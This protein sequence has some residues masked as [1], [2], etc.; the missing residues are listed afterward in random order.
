MFQVTYLCTHGPDYYLSL[1]VT[2]YLVK[3]NNSI[4]FSKEQLHAVNKSFV[5]CWSQFNPIICRPH[6][7]F[8]MKL[9]VLIRYV[10]EK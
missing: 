5:D 9:E 1:H 10:V 8:G 2:L 4:P 7:H 3:Y 6:A